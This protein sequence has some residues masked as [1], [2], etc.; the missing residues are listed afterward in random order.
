MTNYGSNIYKNH[1]GIIRMGWDH[2]Y[3]ALM[4]DKFHGF[5]GEYYAYDAHGPWY[6]DD[7]DGELLFYYGRELNGDFLFMTMH[8]SD[9]MKRVFDPHMMD[10]R[11]ADTTELTRMCIA[12]V[13]K[14]HHKVK[15]YVCDDSVRFDGEDWGWGEY[16]GCEACNN[17]IY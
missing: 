15:C 14:L 1:H 2:V 10:I 8:R 6:E 7:Y 4:E 9:Y 11:D 5:R 3:P 12:D 16:W 17:L 13:A